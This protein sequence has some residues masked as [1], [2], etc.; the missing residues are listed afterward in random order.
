[1]KNVMWASLLAASATMIA[2]CHGGE[3]VVTPG[4]VQTMQ[5]RVVES[6][7][8]H[9]PVNLQS[10]GTVHSRETAVVSAQ[11]TGR[12][13]QVLVHEGDNVR[14]VESQQQHLP[15]NLQSTG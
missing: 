13:Q 12:I 8:Q 10:T 9:L 14:V 6:Q 1:M 15:V 2:G 4:T 5:A 3:S 7:Q 11:V